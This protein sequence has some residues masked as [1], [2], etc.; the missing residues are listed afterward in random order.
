MGNPSH[1]R[2]GCTDKSAFNSE[3][4]AILLKGKHK[5]SLTSN[6]IKK[7]DFCIVIEALIDKI[8]FIYYFVSSLFDLPNLKWLLLSP[9]SETNLNIFFFRYIHKKFYFFFSK[10]R[11]FIFVP[12]VVVS[13]HVKYLNICYAKRPARYN[14]HVPFKISISHFFFLFRF[15][16]TSLYFILL[17][18]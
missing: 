9:I 7:P 6:N 4:I 12:F 3:H 16:S 1:E 8:L 11:S 2:S 17:L 14:K 18:L 5:K 15:F 13:F 10:K